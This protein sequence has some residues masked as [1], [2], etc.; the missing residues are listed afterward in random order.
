M[1]VFGFYSLKTTPVINPI[2]TQ[3]ILVV[4]LSVI[5]TN[6]CRCVFF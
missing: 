1:A 3:V 6:P 4:A 2:I 5:I